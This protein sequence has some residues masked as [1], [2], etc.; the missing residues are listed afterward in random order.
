MDWPIEQPEPMVQPEQ[1]PAQAKAEGQGRSPSTPAPPKVSLRANQGAA[2]KATEGPGA[3]SSSSSNP[4]AGQISVRDVRLTEGPG[5]RQ[6]AD[7]DLQM[8]EKIDRQIANDA[9]IAR[10]L[11]GS[12]AGSGR[13]KGASKGSKQSNREQGQR[14]QSWSSSQRSRSNWWQQQQGWSQDDAWKNSDWWGQ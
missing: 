13:G 11:A 10:G 4:A 9:A 8:R 6:P 2:H 12:M 3:A 1:P 14:G 5:A 7:V